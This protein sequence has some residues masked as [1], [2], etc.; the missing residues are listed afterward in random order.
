MHRPTPTAAIALAA[1]ALLLVAPSASATW[2]RAPLPANHARIVSMQPAPSQPTRVYAGF[3][4]LGVWRTDDRG[5]TWQQKSNGLPTDV[6]VRA[7]AVHATDPDLVLAGSEARE[8]TPGRLYRTTDGG[9]SWTA[10]TVGPSAEGVAAVVFD[11]S[12]PSTAY[13]GVVGG[14]Q[15]G[16]YRSTDAGVAWVHVSGDLPGQSVYAVA[17]DPND[18][19]ALV[20]GI[21]DGWSTS[22]N[23]GTTWVVHYELAKTVVDL[24][25]SPASSARLYGIEDPGS[26]GLSGIR[27]TDGG[28]TFEALA[29]IGYVTY[30][31]AVAPHP[32]EEDVVWA[33]G[34]TGW[35]NGHGRGVYRSTNSGHSWEPVEIR[36]YGGTF[37]GLALDPA[38][39]Q[40]VFVSEDGLP[41]TGLLASSDGGA[42]WETRTAGLWN[43]PVDA[44]IEDTTGD[45]YALFRYQY[46]QSDGSPAAWIDRGAWI[47]GDPYRCEY[48]GLVSS[49]IPGVQYRWG[50]QGSWDYCALSFQ[51]TTDSGT[52]WSFWGYPD[53]FVNGCGGFH[54]VIDVA[55]DAVSGQYVYAT[56]RNNGLLR[57]DTGGGEPWPPPEYTLIN[58]ALDEALITVHPSEPLSVFFA[59]GPLTVEF[60]DDGG[61]TTVPRNGG[62]PPEGD[63][64]KIVELFARAPSADLLA[65]VYSDGRVYESTDLGV[66][67]TLRTTLEPQGAEIVDAAWDPLTGH[68]F[69]ATLGAGILTDHPGVSADLPTSDVRC[70]LYSPSSTILYAGTDHAGLWYGAVASAVD[71]PAL[72]G[73]AG[74][75]L[76]VRPNPFP[77]RARVE[78]SVPHPG[79]YVSLDVV[80]VS[81]RRVRSLARG[82]HAGGVRSLA[83]DG[84]DASGRALPSGVYFLRVD[85]GGEVVSKKVVL[86][87]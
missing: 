35:K 24:A 3:H 48:H 81:G 2:Q 16:L 22:S 57:N 87:R 47:E 46:F 37:T 1:A 23:G 38:A 59:G 8:S 40:K 55:V 72:A 84:R 20:V 71:A 31:E 75:G 9:G 19:A 70:V 63:G 17:V 79:A 50:V 51:K 45:V 30:R 7:L 86:R 42:T 53:D 58:A 5:L 66:S 32:S 43:H 10:V 39:P 76:A 73:A 64:L 52:S 67:W 60:S 26:Q 41:G 56:Q 83:W 13:A 85:R 11:P 33:A 69:L 54:A 12:S 78:F 65:V 80:D 28:A 15:P 68:V 18:P 77:G 14:V 34:T 82:W 29:G 61:A 6:V 44:L 25:W 49:P 21:D 27:S 4:G 36:T 62:L 74:T